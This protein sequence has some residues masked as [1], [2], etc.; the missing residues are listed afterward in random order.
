MVVACPSG[1]WG[2]DCQGDCSCRDSDT[3]CNETTGCAECPEG[4]K[5]GDC[6]EDIDE[7][8]P[9]DPC[10]KHSSCSNTI[11][12]FKCICAAGFTQFN[13]TVCQGIYVHNNN[14]IIEQYKMLIGNIAQ[15]RFRST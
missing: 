3:E 9:K 12:T 8:V 6:H 14:I 5:G 7:C 10:D 2:K 15:C 11:G 4:Y 13:A 1:T